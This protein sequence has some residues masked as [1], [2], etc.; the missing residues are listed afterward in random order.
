MDEINICHVREIDLPEDFRLKLHLASIN[1][2]T[3]YQLAGIMLNETLIKRVKIHWESGK[4][5]TITATDPKRPWRLNLYSGNPAA[6]SPVVEF[7]AIQLPTPGPDYG[8]SQKIE[9]L[10]REI[11]AM[12][13]ELCKVRSD[14]ANALFLAKVYRGENKI[15]KEELQRFEIPMEIRNYRS[16]LPSTFRVN[17]NP[18]NP[19]FFDR[20][21]ALRW[22]NAHRGIINA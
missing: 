15:F 6:I 19:L 12:G 5:T 18:L 21:S 3:I 2:E 13:A 22:V 11:Q 17:V 4:T 14:L 10:E 20:E 8:A 7:T 9:D 1:Y 16:D